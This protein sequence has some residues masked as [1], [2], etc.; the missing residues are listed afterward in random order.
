MVSSP[1]MGRSRYGAQIIARRAK[2]G[3]DEKEAMAARRTAVSRIRFA[4]VKT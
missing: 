3:G 4:A 1:V 2:T